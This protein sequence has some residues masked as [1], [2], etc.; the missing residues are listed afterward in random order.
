MRVD[1]SDQAKSTTLLLRINILLYKLN[2]KN[3]RILYTVRFDFIVIKSLLGDIIIKIIS[4]YY[5]IVIK[6]IRCQLITLFAFLLSN[7]SIF[8]TTTQTSP[9]SEHSKVPSTNLLLQT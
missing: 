5:Y 4:S 8:W 7:M 9:G 6:R 2:I 3:R 1:K